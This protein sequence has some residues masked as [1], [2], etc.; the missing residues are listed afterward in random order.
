MTDQVISDLKDTK[1]DIENEFKRCFKFGIDMA[2]AVGVDPEK[3]RTAKCWSC[4]RDNVP[5]TDCESYN[6]QLL[7][8]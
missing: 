8:L 3:S 1:T 2:T 7:F 4:F 5:G 6:H